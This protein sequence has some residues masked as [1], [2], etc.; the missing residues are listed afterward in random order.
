[1]SKLDTNH[2]VNLDLVKD[3]VNSII[4]F[5]LAD[6]ETSDFYLGLYNNGSRVFNKILLW[7]WWKWK[8]LKNEKTCLEIW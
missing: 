4:K 1:M 7:N 8:L 3:R 6:V 5:G 2:V